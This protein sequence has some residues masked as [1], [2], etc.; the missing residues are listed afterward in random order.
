M[1]PAE[2]AFVGSDLSGEVVKL[3]PNLQKDIKIGD[4]V[5]AS[6]V[7]STFPASPWSPVTQFHKERKLIFVN[8]CGGEQMS[9]VDAALSPNTRRHIPTLSGR[10][11]RELTP[12]KRSLQPAYRRPIIA[13]AQPISSLTRMARPLGSTQHS[14]PC[15][16]PELS[17]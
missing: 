7:G 5:G 4:V 9:R 17:N 12:S 11:P 16:D 8:T 15:T 1:Y 10:F 13:F 14:K 6:I 2:G 3:G